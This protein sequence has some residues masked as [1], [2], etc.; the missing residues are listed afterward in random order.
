MP[1]ASTATPTKPDLLQT[2]PSEAARQCNGGS[3]TGM[4]PA[5]PANLGADANSDRP[6]SEE[7][8]PRSLIVGQLLHG[9]KRSTW[10]RVSPAVRCGWSEGEQRESSSK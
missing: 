4:V 1:L 10:H 2:L 6:G 5:P 9:M 3:P 8:F 7:C